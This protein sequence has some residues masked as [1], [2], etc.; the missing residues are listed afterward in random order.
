M[1]EVMEAIH[2]LESIYQDFDKARA[3]VREA[4]KFMQV[5]SE[6]SLT[7]LREWIAGSAWRDVKLS[8]DDLRRF[9]GI[10]KEIYP[11][12]VSDLCAAGR[13][14]FLQSSGIAACPQT[15]NLFEKQR[16]SADPRLERNHWAKR[17]FGL[18][19]SE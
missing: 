10:R 11:C 15:R 13:F 5:R 3:F 7:T 12:L 4:V 1:A 6:N 8:D 2:Y 14:P 19:V 16:R 9:L 17:P 18:V